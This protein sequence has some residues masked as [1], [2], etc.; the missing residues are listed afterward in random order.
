MTATKII[1]V[2]SCIIIKNKR[3]FGDTGFCTVSLKS[4]KSLLLSEFLK[5]PIDSEKYAHE[6]EDIP[7]PATTA[8]EAPKLYTPRLKEFE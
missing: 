3:A 2:M 8:R 4:G 5:N 1:L 7:L 6:I